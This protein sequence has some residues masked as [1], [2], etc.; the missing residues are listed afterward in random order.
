MDGT[1]DTTDRTLHDDLVDEFLH[2]APRGPRLWAVASVD[3]ERAASFATDLSTT[4]GARGIAA[5]TIAAGDV[6]ADAL[7][8]DVTGPFRA[9]GE[10]A[11]LLVTGGPGALDEQHRVLWHFSVW[12]LAGDETPHTAASALVDVTDPSYPTR[13]FGDYCAVPPTWRS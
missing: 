1:S 10:D 3:E 8:A 11:V 6:S 9:R 5:A 12:L 4:L 13:R 7:R 2:A